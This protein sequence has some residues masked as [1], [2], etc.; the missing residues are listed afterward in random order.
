MLDYTVKQRPDGLTISFNQFGRRLK[1]VALWSSFA[2]IC[3]AA[4]WFL[5]KLFSLE[6]VLNIAFDVLIA[7]VILVAFAFFL[8]AC[9]VFYANL[10]VS[11]FTFSID[12]IHDCTSFLGMPWRSKWYPRAGIY[13]FCHDFVAHSSTPVLKFAFVAKGSWVIL[14]EH[15]SKDEAD[16]FIAYL[17]S[18]GYQYEESW[19]EPPRPDRGIRFVTDL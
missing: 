17:R 14:A 5:P 1:G 6:S 16:Q 3:V 12:G 9:F 19:Q 8:F 4:L 10:Q 7:L 15:V 13:A 11:R 2:V 18:E